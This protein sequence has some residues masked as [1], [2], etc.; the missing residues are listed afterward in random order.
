M[1]RR[2][3]NVLGGFD[4]FVKQNRFTPRTTSP[5]AAFSESNPPEGLHFSSGYDGQMRPGVPMTL[6]LLRRMEAVV[7][8]GV[9]IQNAT[10]YLGAYLPDV[11]KFGAD[12]TKSWCD[13]AQRKQGH[14]VY[15]AP[16]R[17]GGFIVVW[18]GVP[19][20]QNVEA[21]LTELTKSIG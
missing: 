18:K 16:A 11:G 13:T 20:R 3:R 19:S 6:L 10:L 8:Q 5:V 21:R 14:V 7:V 2:K 1:L 9:S 15:A 12:F 4:A 17:E